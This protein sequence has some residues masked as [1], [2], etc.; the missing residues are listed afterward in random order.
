MID[1]I[2]TADYA[3]PFGLSTT[4]DDFLITYVCPGVP[5]RVGLNFYLF[6]DT[7]DKENEIVRRYIDCHK[8]HITA[9]QLSQDGKLLATGSEN[10][11]QIRLYE[12]FTQTPVA[13][14][15]RGN[16]AAVVTGIYFSNDYQFCSVSCG[17]GVVTIF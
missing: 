1:V 7:D 6:S 15:K 8:S 11:K 16:D 14:W 10:G 12:T 2:N 5:G 17:R 3:P 13:C 4:E 9:L